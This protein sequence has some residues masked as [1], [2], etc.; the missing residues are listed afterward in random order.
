MRNALTLQTC[1]VKMGLNESANGID[2]YRSAY[3]DKKLN[4][5][6]LTLD[7]TIPTIIN[8]KEYDFGKTVGKGENAVNP[9]QNN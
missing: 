5:K 2:L 4:V 9:F 1:S 7:H 3:T 8:R 6:C